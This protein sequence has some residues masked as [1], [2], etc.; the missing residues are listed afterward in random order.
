[1]GTWIS[2]LPQRVEAPAGEKKRIF[3]LTPIPSGLIYTLSQ[4]TGVLASG[5]SGIGS[6]VKQDSKGLN[7]DIRGLP[8]KVGRE[9]KKFLWSRLFDQVK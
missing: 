1:M 3:F 5:Q 2:T 6:K 9:I 4:Q 8:L 7:A